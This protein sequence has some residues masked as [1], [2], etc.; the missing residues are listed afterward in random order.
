VQVHFYVL[1]RIC[2]RS[3]SIGPKAAIFGHNSIAQFLQNHV[4]KY[5][6]GLCLLFLHSVCIS[7][8]EYVHQVIFL[9]EGWYD[10]VNDTLVVPPS[11]GSYDPAT[12][13]YAVFDILPESDFAS[14][15]LV[16]D[17]IYVAADNHLIT[18]DKNTLTRIQTVTIPGIREIAVWN[19]ELLISRGDYLISF[20]SYFQVYDKHSLELL[21]ELDTENGPAY[22]SEGIVIRDDHAYLAINNGFVFGEEVGLVGV[23]DLNSRTYTAEIDLGPAGINPDNIMVDA[24]KIYTLNNKNYLSSSISIVD[25]DSGDVS[26]YDMIAANSGCGTSTLAA[27][28]IYFMEYGVDK[29]ARFDV[30]SSQVVDTLVG[31][32]AYYG[33]ID[34][35]VNGQLIATWTDFFSQ[36]TAYIL[37]YD[38][39]VQH[40]FDV[41]VSPGSIALDVRMSTGI[42]DKFSAAA[43]HVF[44]NPALDV[45]SFESD[46]LIRSVRLS[47]LTGAVI[48]DA[49][50]NQTSGSLSLGAYPAGMYLVRLEM[51]SGLSRT[52]KV[53]KGVID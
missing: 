6:Y 26:T 41:G 53:V 30:Q 25:P 39:T 40:A 28:H 11:V 52:M 9:N 14:D 32:G 47:S 4:M 24:D 33:L 23:I 15:V 1:V 19:N 43:I 2:P 42:N 50:V 17:V 22:A 21:Y 49:V 12:E 35:S 10:F 51:Q 18:Y 36:G 31:T 20:D 34:D 13:T 16:D 27:G 5:I 29:L 45:I 37:S 7:A 44:P 3:F 8:Q 46:E 48:Q 38:G